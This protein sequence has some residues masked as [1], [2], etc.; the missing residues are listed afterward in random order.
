[1]SDK[2]SR[3]QRKLEAMLA[4]NTVPGNGAVITVAKD[5]KKVKVRAIVYPSGGGQPYEE[6][7]QVGDDGTFTLKGSSLTFHV[8]KGSVIRCLDGQMRVCVREDQAQTVNLSTLK[9]E[10]I[11]HPMTLNAIAENNYWKQWGD[12]LNRKAFWRQASTWG[13][14]A[15]GVCIV[16]ALVWNVKTTG[17]GFEDLKNA[18]ETYAGSASGGTTGNPSGHNPIAPGGTT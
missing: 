9:G 16:L 7:V 3:R 5:S 8:T 1:M 11:M 12:F 15:V 4:K 10:N 6:D 13:M 2:P 18:W 17:N 14:I